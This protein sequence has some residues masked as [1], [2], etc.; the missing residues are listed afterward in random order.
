MYVLQAQATTLPPISL[1][2]T[3]ASVFVIGPAL[4]T[5]KDIQCSPIPTQANPWYSL[6]ESRG[7]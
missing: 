7:Q 6:P 4:A 1:G 3:Q 5:F 2:P